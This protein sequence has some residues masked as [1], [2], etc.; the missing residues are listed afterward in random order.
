[1]ENKKIKLKEIK[2][3]SKN[4]RYEPLK[5]VNDNL[6][7]FFLSESKNSSDKD[8][9]IDLLKNEGNLNDFLSLIDNIAKNGFKDLESTIYTIENDGKYIV[10]EGNRRMSC[11][12]IL[13]QD[14]KLPI[15]ENISS[16]I[17]YNNE[18]NDLITDDYIENEDEKSI[19]K[20]YLKI[21][22]IVK[23]F[24]NSTLDTDEIDVKIFDKDESDKIWNII[25]LRN[26]S[27]KQIGKREWSRSKYLLD[28]L[29]FVE[30]GDLEEEIA[31]S[32]SKKK[33][34]IIA[35]I[36]QAKW[37]QL[38]LVQ[39]SDDKIFDKDEM[40]K[41]Q[42]SSLQTNFCLGIFDEAI[43]RLEKSF[44][45]K[46]YDLDKS[47]VDKKITMLNI[48]KI[49]NSNYK[50]NLKLNKE[51]SNF[52]SIAKFI[53]KL[54][55]EK[56]ITTRTNIKKD[57]EGSDMIKAEFLLK[58]SE[59]TEEI[60]IKNIQLFNR[61]ELKLLKNSNKNS[62][63]LEIINLE[64]DIREY[65]DKFKEV[66][67]N[68]IKSSLVTRLKEPFFTCIRELIQIHVKIPK[69]LPNSPHLLSI[70]LRCIFEQLIY[71]H[72]LKNSKK[73]E[74]ILDE[75][76]DKSFKK[77]FLKVQNQLTNDKIE[78]NESNKPVTTLQWFIRFISNQDFK[79]DKNLD[80]IISFTNDIFNRGNNS[81]HNSIIHFNELLRISLDK[82]NILIHSIQLFYLSNSESNIK[83]SREIILSSEKILFE[84]FDLK[85]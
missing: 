60:D 53:F 32:L 35:D 1:M 52:S 5:S 18:D 33:S 16:N 15:F 10:V 17:L 62:K 44:L 81:S 14:I 40:S 74:K 64:L 38:L 9:I 58:K 46:A 8:I 79:K 4:P 36:R 66:S 41:L 54:F 24:D 45:I 83:I 85:N 37:I 80:Y 63:Y 50:I 84:Y 39:K 31:K 56:K 28:I 20:N 59:I 6:Y 29:S 12:K 75:F 7:N 22:E 77:D 78:F 43:E 30:N 51:I 70:S 49:D 65:R 25:Y 11:L 72:I 3:C 47:F 48:L 34:S 21:E 82:L 42:V 23:N 67:D 19:K 55:E 26:I 27:G 2:L 57:F 61:D 71:N 13:R 68:F 69:N 76:K 73:I